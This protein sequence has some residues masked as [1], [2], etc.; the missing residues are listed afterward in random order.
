[1]LFYLL[2]ELYFSKKKKM[3]RTSIEREKIT[4]LFNSKDLKM[5]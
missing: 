4:F 2:F 3:R 1:M 5:V